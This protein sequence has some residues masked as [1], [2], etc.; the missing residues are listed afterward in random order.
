MF[1][2][3]SCHLA[4]SSHLLRLLA[5][6]Q[7]VLR[8][9]GQTAVEGVRIRAKHSRISRL[10]RLMPSAAATSEF[11]AQDTEL[12]GLGLHTEILAALRKAGISRPARIQVRTVWACACAPEDVEDPWAQGEAC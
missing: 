5:A 11:Y 7:F 12:E 6:M 2:R 8:P 3:A 4:E 9:P 10:P 1:A